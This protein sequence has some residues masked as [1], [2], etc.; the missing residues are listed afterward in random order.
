M[1]GCLPEE[2]EAEP[3]V[4]APDGE[5]ER[6]EGDA[7]HQGGDGEEEGGELLC[8][9]PAQQ[10]VQQEHRSQ[11]KVCKII[12]WSREKCVPTDLYGEPVLP[13]DALLQQAGVGVQHVEHHGGQVA[14]EHEHHQQPPAET[15]PA[16][17]PFGP[18][19]NLAGKRT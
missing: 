2:P 7:V 17:D 16:G 1:S 15:R 6:A 3:G 5:E 8:R 11:R 18:L 14:A 13:A 10:E 9:H 4:A 12:S 19:L